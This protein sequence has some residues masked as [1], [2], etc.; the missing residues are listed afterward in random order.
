LLLPTSSLPI[1]LFVVSLGAAVVDHRRRLG[2]I[3]LGGV[4]LG[5]FLVA[6]SRSALFFLIA[7]PVVMVV[8]G[9]AA[10]SHSAASSAGIGLV[11]VAF[12]VL[13][14]VSFASAGLELA[15]PIDVGPSATPPGASPGVSPGV[16]PGTSPGVSPGASPTALA[17][18][19]RTTA[20]PEAAFIP[21]I[22]AFL[23]SPERDGSIRERVAQYGVAWDLF[24]S[25]PLVGV[26]L[27]HSFVWE[28][29]DGTIR[30]DI[31]A[32]TPLVLP[33]KLGVLGIAWLALFIAVW[34][35]FLQKLRRAAGVTLPGLAMTA[36][37]AILGVLA[38]G[39][40][41]LEDKGFSF[42][43]MLL[44]SL[45]FIEIERAASPDRA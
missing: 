22:Q 9:R 26:G 28:R 15:P 16:S 34:I 18:T 45:A 44:L 41:N 13:V 25:S 35:R 8:A 11:A 21:R 27:G 10:L 43:L 7:L 39:S 40:F 36:W 17:P 29:V 2:W 42:A 19:P 20:N 30:S 33:A 12:V 31:T 4:T 37:A 24:V 32:D 14:Q 3:V 38:W 23:T 1:A 6:G 5:I